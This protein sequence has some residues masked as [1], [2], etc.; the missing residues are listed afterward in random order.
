[1]SECRQLCCFLLVAGSVG[2]AGCAFVRCAANSRLVSFAGRNRRVVSG[3][4]CAGGR[5]H[6]LL[7]RRVADVA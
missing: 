6:A 4:A 2:R 1:M 3:A 7:S 5:G